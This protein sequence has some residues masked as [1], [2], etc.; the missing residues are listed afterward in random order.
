MTGTV[1]NVNNEMPS[2]K[3]L[4]GTKFSFPLT[5][6]RIHR[7]IISDIIR[8]TLFILTSL[9]TPR[10]QFVGVANEVKIKRVTR[11]EYFYPSI[12]DIS[13]ALFAF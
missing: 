10:S 2:S 5:C 1:T 3:Y 6:P 9:V 11:I 12:V 13:D 8:V 7:L 4:K